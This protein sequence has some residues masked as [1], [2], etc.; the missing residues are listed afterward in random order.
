M[1]MV[2]NISF[3]NNL[4]LDNPLD[5]FGKLGNV[6]NISDTNRSNVNAVSW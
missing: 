2:E 1:L 6:P 4:V 3:F 5:S